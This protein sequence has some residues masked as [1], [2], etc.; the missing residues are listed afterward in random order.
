MT[1]SSFQQNSLLYST[2]K[3]LKIDRIKIQKQ[4]QKMAA[5]TSREL[6]DAFVARRLQHIIIVMVA[7]EIRI[8]CNRLNSLSIP[9]WTV[10][11]EQGLVVG[12]FIAEM[13][14]VV[15]KVVVAIRRTP[16]SV[17]VVVVD[18]KNSN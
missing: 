2:Q 5:G 15:I 4:L 16:I 9:V 17:R 11:I 13:W 6:H 3:L 10:I 12:R 8:N 7:S 14:V 1:F 18:L